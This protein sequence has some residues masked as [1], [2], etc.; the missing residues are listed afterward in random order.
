MVTESGFGRCGQHERIGLDQLQL[1]L[2]I[3]F[4]LQWPAFRIGIDMPPVQEILIGDLQL[5]NRL[6]AINRWCEERHACSYSGAQ[7][8]ERQNSSPSSRERMQNLLKSS[9]LVI[10]G[11]RP[12]LIIAA[13]R[14]RGVH[15]LM[16]F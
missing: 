10:V 14:P 11:R 12:L 7:N 1:S 15:D 13:F 2:K 6:G 16:E 4:G 3:R 8:R 9:E 5:H